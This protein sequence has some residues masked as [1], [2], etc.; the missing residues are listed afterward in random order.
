MP[1]ELHYHPDVRDVDIPAINANMR[2]RIKRAIETRLA[3]APH[4]YGE[5]LRKTLKGYWKLRVGDY[6]VVFKIAGNE[7]W[8]LGIMDRKEV[9][10]KIGKRN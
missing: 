6:R 4:R 7:V 2:A 9:Y 1:F 3:A 8:I 10:E 5:P